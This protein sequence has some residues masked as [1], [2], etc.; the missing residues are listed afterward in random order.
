[1]TLTLTTAEARARVIA[2]FEEI[3]VRKEAAVDPADQ[4]IILHWPGIYLGAL[5]RDG[6]AAATA[7]EAATR[8]GSFRA[9][10]RVVIH[11]GHGQRA[12]PIAR[13]VALAADIA[14]VRRMIEEMKS[15]PIA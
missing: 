10:E 14:E 8:F 13:Q 11:N 15:A 3:L 1:V 12:E 2:E 7:T 9:A 6:S 4:T 5:V